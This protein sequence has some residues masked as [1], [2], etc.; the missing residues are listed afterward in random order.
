MTMIRSLLRWWSLTRQATDLEVIQAV[1]E[2]AIRDNEQAFQEISE[3]YQQKVP[4]TQLKLR[5][6]LDKAGSP[7]IDLENLMHEQVI[8]RQRGMNHHE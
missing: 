3:V 8:K 4:E 2:N 5:S 1:T 6:S 7:F